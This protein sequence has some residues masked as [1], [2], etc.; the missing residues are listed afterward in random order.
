MRTAF[1]QIQME[2]TLTHDGYVVVDFLNPGEFVDV[3]EHIRELEFGED[4]EKK[5][6]ISINDDTIEKKNDIYKKF[7][8]LFQGAAD[9]F[10]QD[11]KI[12]RIAIFDKLPG[13]HGISAHQHPHFVD[14]S[15]FRSLTIWMPLTDT[16]VEMGTLFVVKGSHNIF[17]HTIRTQNDFPIFNEV[18]TKTVK[19]Y[20]TPLLLKAGQAVIF[21]DR[22]IHWSPPN[23]SSRIRTAF[24]LMYV[25]QET[26]E[27]LTIYYRDKMPCLLKNRMTWNRLKH[28]NNLVLDMTTGNLCQ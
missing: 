6:R 17:I 28:Q 23:K 14:E 1:K 19:K 10:L 26:A 12:M 24:Q 3:Q 4:Y 16:T 21:D 13:G 15:K 25:P 8:P 2:D 5:Y 20:S 11:Y 22:L 9:R 7:S 18:S 27:N